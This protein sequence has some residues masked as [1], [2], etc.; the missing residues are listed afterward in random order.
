ATSEHY[1]LSLHDALPILSN[2]SFAPRYARP[3]N[4]LSNLF[5]CVQTEN[6]CEISLVKPINYN[7]II[8]GWEFIQ[9][10]L[11]SLHNREISQAN[12]RS[13]EHTSELQS[14]ENLVC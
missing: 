1:T 14:R 9:Q 11:M 8:D 12:L 5:R 13:E 2:W 7:L 10:I 6:G 4:T 3:G